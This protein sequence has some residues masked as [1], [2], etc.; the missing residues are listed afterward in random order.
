MSAQNQ[1]PVNYTEPVSLQCRPAGCLH[2]TRSRSTTRSQSAHSVDLLDVCTEPAASQLHGASQLT[3]YTCWMSAQNQQPVNYTEP[4]S[5]QC[6]PA[7]CLHRTSS[8][9]TTRSQ[10]AYSV[11]LLD[12]CTE[13][14][15]SQLH[16]A[17]QLTV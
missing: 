9:S 3:V 1:Q 15:A 5:S 11:D 7:G 10:S 2:R 14:A 12:V 8:Q 16:G 4:V 6:R 17:S 13:P